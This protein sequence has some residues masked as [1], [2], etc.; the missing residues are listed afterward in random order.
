MRGAVPRKPI[1]P[2]FAFA[3]SP[4]GVSNSGARLENSVY[5]ELRWR[6]RGTR[7]RT[8][9]YYSTAASNEVDF[10]VGDPESGHA[11]QLLQ[12]CA[13]LSKPGAREREVRALANAIKETGRLGTA[14]AEP[15]HL[16]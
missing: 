13:D 8:I 4:V 6:L 5:L 3:G 15:R 12:V 14:S 2:G 7:E 9:S 1:D 10:I 16:R 11:T